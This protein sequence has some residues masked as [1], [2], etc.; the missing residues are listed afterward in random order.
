[1]SE[2]ATAN[3][4]KSSSRLCLLACGN[5]TVDR[6]IECSAA[7]L[8]ELG[9]GVGTSTA[10]RDAAFKERTLA[11]AM[12][13]GTVEA[14]T[15][16]GCELNT[17]R[18]AAGR[19]GVAAAFL[20]CVGTDPDGD[21]LRRAA[22]DAGVRWLLPPVSGVA[23]GVCAVLVDVESRDRS[24]VTV[25][26]AAR[27]LCPAHLEGGDVIAALHEAAIV[28]VTSFTLSTPS[29]VAVVRSM[30]SAAQTSGATFAMNLASEGIQKLVAPELAAL[31]PQ[32][33]LLFGNK[34]ELLAFAEVSGIQEDE[35]FS[36]LHADG[37][38]VVTQGADPTLV[39]GPCLVAP[40]EYPVPPV[41][42][43]EIADTNCAG[44]SF[45]AG[46]LAA[47]QCQMS[48]PGR[49]SIATDP[50]A[51]SACVTQGHKAAAQTLRMH[52]C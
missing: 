46:F 30:A 26:G 40:V 13:S 28:Y 9:L 20:G 42:K 18:V 32:T 31:L 12:T 6:T 41:P 43:E 11:A 8:D 23:T 35:I 14:T 16:G 36:R 38:L 27:C 45:V 33:K 51:L 22:A 1:M 4:G 7:V 47:Y 19:F 34:Q 37:L 21:L 25:P 2:D 24:L 39:S 44:D 5:P 10:G 29:R 52:G 15:P 50:G 17:A 49:T 3:S 48:L